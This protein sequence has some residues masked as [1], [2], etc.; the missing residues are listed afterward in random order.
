MDKIFIN[1]KIAQLILLQRIDL[2][3][4]FLIRMR[5]L[6]GRK[7]FTKFV[8]KYLINPE[9]IGKKYINDMEEEYKNISNYYDFN[10]KDILSIGSGIG[11]LELIINKKNDVNRFSLIDKN[12]ISEKVVYGWDLKNSEAYNDLELVQIFLTK[13][14]VSKEKI[15][16]FD[17]DKDEFPLED[18]DI[19]ISLFSLDYHYSYELY[20]DYF[21]KI[22]KNKT[23]LIFDTIRPQY[24]ESLFHS[25]KI[26]KTINNSV[27][28]S[29]RIICSGAK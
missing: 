1:K 17:F 6:F 4:S 26:I 9:Q 18:F 15:N 8:S 22:M 20:S 5:K 19:I 10:N 2:A 3:S 23:T 24:F 13:N 25:V 7:F 12:Y 28:K 27:H 14:G 29:S 16:I 11:G 21:K